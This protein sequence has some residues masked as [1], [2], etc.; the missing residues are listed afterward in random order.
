MNLSFMPWK[1]VAIYDTICSGS[2]KNRIKC[3]YL[4]NVQVVNLQGIRGPSV[5]FSPFNS[6]KFIFKLTNLWI[7]LIYKFVIICFIYSQFN[8]S[9]DSVENL[10]FVRLDNNYFKHF[11]KLKL[12]GPFWGEGGGIYRRYILFNRTYSGSL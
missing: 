3:D 11:H 8:K 5:Y 12:M 4:H 2:S 1:I 6:M 10:F 9:S 7:S